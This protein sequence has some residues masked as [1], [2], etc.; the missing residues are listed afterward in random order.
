MK[1]WD[2]ESKIDLKNNTSKNQKMFRL[3]FCP[4]NNYFRFFEANFIINE[5]VKIYRAVLL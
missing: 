1:I 2:R 5:R 4:K 3:K